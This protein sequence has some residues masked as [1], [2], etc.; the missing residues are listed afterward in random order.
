MAINDDIQYF[1]SGSGAAASSLGGAVHAN[2]VSSA[3]DGNLFGNVDSA[4]ALAGSSKYRCLYIK[5]NGAVS[6]NVGLYL[7]TT[8]P[9]QETQILIGNGTS[10]VNGSEQSVANEDTEPSG[11]LWVERLQDFNALSIATLAPGDTKAV[12][13]KRIVLANAGGSTQDYF[14]LSAVAQ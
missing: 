5:N 2:Q 1:Y 12:W 13:L 6:Y 8:T 14:I 4:E 7:S 3:Q 11:V 9:S 10:A